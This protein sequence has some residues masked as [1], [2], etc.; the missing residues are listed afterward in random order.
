MAPKTLD[1]KLAELRLEVQRDL[2]PLT[3]PVQ[4][5]TQRT[6]RAT[7]ANSWRDLVPVILVGM[8]KVTAI[9]AFPFVVYVR[10][11][12]FF[13]VHGAPSWL[14]ITVGA[15]LTMGI[16]AGYAAWLSR[17]FRGRA[18]VET[19]SRW[20][21][22]PLVAFWCAYSL[23]HLAKTNAK[24]D[25]VRKEYAALHPVLRVALSTV[26]LADPD[27]VVTDGQR[28]ASDYARMG[29]PV[30]DR[31]RHYRQSDGWVHAVDL[32][33]LGRGEIENRTVQAY[34]WAMGFRT[35]R[36]VGT[37]DHLHIQL[38]PR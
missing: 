3:R 18:R 24:S 15:L 8:L 6:T 2:R 26:I 21:A 17:R 23:L 7:R 36:H 28:T 22:L 20:I 29:L 37:A 32:R 35:L 4:R 34:F 11:A 9:V 16:V 1:A 33:T 30:N 19:V 5:A 12:V 38:R 10:S 27:L 25:E 13:Y 31:T 14:A